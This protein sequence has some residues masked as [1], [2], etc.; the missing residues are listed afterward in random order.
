MARLD[1]V[2]PKWQSRIEPWLNSCGAQGLS[3]ADK[4]RVFAKPIVSG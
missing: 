1:H 3:E 4:S 2:G